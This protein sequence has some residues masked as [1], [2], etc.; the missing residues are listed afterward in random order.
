MEVGEIPTPT[1]GPGQALVRVRAAALN[2]I[3]VWLRR[4][5][6]ALKV[7]FPHVSG[8]DVCGDLAALGPGAG[9]AAGLREGDRIVVN[10]GISC[11]RCARCLEGE[12]NLCADYHMVGE[13]TWGGEA[14][15]LVVPAAN[16]VPAPVGPSD[17][18]LASL[19]IAFLTAWQMLI[20]KARVRPEETVLVLAAGSG[21]GVAA[22][23][24][25]R[26]AGARVIAAASTAEK[27]ALARRLGAHE[28][29]NY[30]DA[31]ITAECRRL[32]GGKGIDVVFE[33]VG[34]S[35]FPASIKVAA[36]GGRIVTCG[37][38]DGF[39]TLLDLRYVYWRQLSI[40]GSTL[41]SK[42][43]L[44]RLLELVKSGQLKAVVDRVL[45][46][47]QIAEGHRVIE[48]RHVLG[49]VVMG[50]A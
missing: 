49:K 29:I 13:K 31:N 19:P 42:G 17:V 15:Y 35:T 3:D 7:P 38:T 41:A 10:P 27:L 6:P 47:E 48:A 46:L 18:E 34:A 26:L 16:L 22:V 25:A 21:V 32:T 37:A 11:G 4:G 28:T 23:Q 24:I 8:G 36:K 33:H 30:K 1:P 39:E 2:H 20:D 50:I 5:L 45:P 12:D 14:E 40:L 43:R 44:F 9:V